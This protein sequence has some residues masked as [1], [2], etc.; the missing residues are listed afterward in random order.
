MAP[1]SEFGFRKFGFIVIVLILLIFSF[2]AL[3]DTGTA[4]DISRTIYSGRTLGM[5]GAHVGLSNDGEG[6]FI[7]PSGLANLEFPQI[8][9]LSRNLM[10]NETSYTLGSWVVP[11]GWGTFGV[12]FAGAQTGGSFPTSRD[13]GTGR[14]VLNSSLEALSQDSNVIFLSYARPLSWNNL[15]VGG[16]LKFFNESLNGGGQF[17]HA[18]AFGVD[19]SASYKP[20]HY[21]NLGANVQ[22]FLGSGMAWNTASEKLGGYLKL[23]GA[24]NLFG[25]DTRE[26]FLQNDQNVV[27][28]LDMDLPRDVMGAGLQFHAGLEW[29][30]ISMLALRAGINQE[31]GDTGF[32]FGAGLKNTAFRFDYAFAPRP[33]ITGDTP[34]YFSLSYVG[35]RIVTYSKKMK[36]KVSGFK[37]LFP[38]DRSI[39]SLESVTLRAEAKGKIIS[40]QKT[41]WTVPLFE[42]TSEVREVFELVDLTDVRRNGYPITQTGTIEIS[43]PLNFGRNV[44]ALEGYLPSESFR[45][46]DEVKVLRIAPFNDVAMDYWALAP[47]ALNSVL[48]L[49]KGYPD[50]TFRPEKGITRAE[51]TALL[52]RTGNIEDD[53]WEQAKS[54][55]KF[56][57]IKG[58]AW[59]APYVNYGVELG[60]VTGYPDKTFRPNQVLNR[61][62]GVT[63]LA[64]FAKLAEKDGVAFKDLKDTF[65]ANKFIL[66]AKEAGL[67][68]YLEGWNFEPAKPFPRSEAAEVLY[69]TSPI[70]KKVNDFWNTGMISA[71]GQL[72]KPSTM[73]AAKAKIIETPTK[74]F[75][76]VSVPST[77]EA[78]TK[79]AT[80][81][82][83]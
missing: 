61:A 43:T 32:T 77:G 12:G 34:H 20:Y 62:E 69:R 70:Q 6:L 38:A 83:R 3:A 15:S 65:W 81:E 21:L 44:I 39:T 40:D 78:K 52:V 60:L 2:P 36:K 28:C 26:A 30:P 64:R 66:P 8:M 33:G 82:S 53:K 7:N 27:A 56:K 55:V 41:V 79:P 48:G 29:T 74:S 63:I 22:N 59:Y 68:K 35:D 76:A 47:I 51:L 9:G 50:N 67:L 11:T 49:I 31:N 4:T 23:G 72:S 58:T 42:S 1:C 54:E 37:F 16:N 57:D 80:L 45:I 73:E 10:L 14:I 25:P 46:T 24:L 75:T 18:G 13:P 19:L 71:A 5:G 17:N